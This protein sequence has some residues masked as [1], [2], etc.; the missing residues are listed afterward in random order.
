MSDQTLRINAGYILPVTSPVIQNGSILINN[1]RIQ[2]I[3]R[4]NDCPEVAPHQVSSYPNHLLMPGLVN[5]HTHLSLSNLKNKTKGAI[6]FVDWIKEIILHSNSMT[7]LDEKDAVKKGI[8]KLISSGTT[9]IGDISGSGVSMELMRDM[10]LRGVVFLEIIGFKKSMKNDQMNWID[11]FLRLSKSN[12]QVT[13]GL[14]PH[15]PYSVSPQLIQS[16]YHLAKSEQLPL[17]MHIAETVDELEFIEKGEGALRR[18][19]E[20]RGKWEP[21]WKPQ[22]KSPIKYLESLN[23]LKGITGIHLNHMNEEDLKIIKKKNMSVVYC[24]K[25]NQWFQRKGPYPLMKFLKNKINVAI[26]TDSLASNDKLNMFEELTLI[27]TDFPDIN[28]KILLQMATING[29]K[30]LGLENVTGSLETGKKADIIAL[31]I[32]RDDNIYK[33]IFSAGGDIAFSMVEGEMIFP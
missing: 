23:V 19:L 2:F 12:G 15:A 30:A 6:C 14:S 13:C 28:D 24:P 3:G 20:D 11:R 4:E 7:D 21:D 33:S 5:A 16:A 9:T 31:K 8:K 26:G 17:A 27:K 22:K 32:N 25:S 29:A 18:F 1:G 10:K